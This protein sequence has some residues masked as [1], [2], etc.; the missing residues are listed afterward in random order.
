MRGKE[1]EIRV[2]LQRG[3]GDRRPRGS[4]GAGNVVTLVKRGNRATYL[5]SRLKRDR[6]DIAEAVERGEYRSIRRAALAAGI[7]REPSP[8]RPLTPASPAAAIMTRGGWAEGRAV[9]DYKGDKGVFARVAAWWRREIVQEVPPELAYCEFEC[10]G[11]HAAP[12]C[13]C[14]LTR[15]RDVAVYRA[16]ERMVHRAA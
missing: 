7:I 13:S 6:P 11:R 1:S 3:A 8:P 16:I 9:A 14:L 4:E 2:P 15:K 5:A 12:K 10:R